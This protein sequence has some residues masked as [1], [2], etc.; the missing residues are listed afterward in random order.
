MGLLRLY[1]KFGKIEGEI[2][3]LTYIKA[4]LDCLETNRNS[5]DF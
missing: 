5:T 2:K 1:L 4:E 3:A